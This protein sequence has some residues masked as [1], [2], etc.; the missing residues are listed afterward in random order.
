M[1]LIILA[2]FGNRSMAFKS[3]D[4][5]NLEGRN[6]GGKDQKK[7][8]KKLKSI[9]LSKLSG[10]N[11]SSRRATW[12]FDLSAIDLAIEELDSMESSDAK[13]ENFEVSSFECLYRVSIKLM[14]IEKK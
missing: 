5:Q 11:S 10:L 12:Q 2:E 8:M 4:S 9:K 6:R 14:H 7:K 1:I 3:S 13:K